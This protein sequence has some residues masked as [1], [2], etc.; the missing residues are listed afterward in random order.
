MKITTMQ[1]S[2]V[3]TAIAGLGVRGD[4]SLDP[5]GKVIEFIDGCAAELKADG[6]AEVQAFQGYCE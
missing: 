4:E 3:F 2:L 1:A 5:L 6:V